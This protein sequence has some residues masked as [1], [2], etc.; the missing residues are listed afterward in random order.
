M[1]HFA[2]FLL[3]FQN[4]LDQDLIDAPEL[5]HHFEVIKSLVTGD[6]DLIEIDVCQTKNLESGQLVII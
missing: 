6:E 4:H 3:S 2:Q 5:G 1:L